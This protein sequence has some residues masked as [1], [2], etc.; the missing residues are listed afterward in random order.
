MQ[1]KGHKSAPPGLIFGLTDAILALGLAVVIQ[2]RGSTKDV[3]PV[4]DDNPTFRTPLVTIG[5]IVAMIGVWVFVQDG[6]FT[7]KTLAATVCNWGMIPGAITH[8]LPLGAATRI[9]PDA[10]C[11]VHD[12]PQVWLTPL[13]SMFL[14]GSWGHVLGNA[15]FLWV[16]G[17]NVEDV[18]GRGRF[19]VFYLL[20]GLVAA[21]TQVLVDPSSPIPTVGASG[22]IAGTLGAY[23]LMYPQVS[24]RMFFPPVFLFRLPAWLVLIFWFGIQFL[25]GLPQI[26]A[27]SPAISGGVAVWAH[28]GGFV[29]GML[30]SGLF[31]DRD[32]VAR[33]LAEMPPKRGRL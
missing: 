29:S 18:M 33:H 6:G 8:L 9:S 15:L 24:V 22:A 1:S 20:C 16:F 4:S 7:E 12:G 2:S 10:V 19:L 23:L 21:G 27:P 3:F 31:V 25:S 5:L 17:N 30:L 28:V 32:L 26:I 11:A 14:H 13:A